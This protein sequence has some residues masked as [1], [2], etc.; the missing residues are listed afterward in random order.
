V[1]IWGTTWAA[2][3]VGLTG[4][5]PLTG[6][7]LR[8]GLAGS[9]LWAVA[10]LLGLRG[11]R[12]AAPPV[13]WVCHGLLTFGVSYGLVYWGEQW[14]PSG[15]AAVLFATF[16]LWVALIAH[17]ALP[18]ERL[19]RRSL[20]G[21]VLG[22]AGVAV[23]FSEDL[24]ALG[25]PQVAFAAAVMLLS[26]LASA[27]AQI[28]VKRWGGQVH[29]VPLNAGAMIIAAATVGVLAALVERHRPVE[30]TGAAVASLLYLALIGTAVAFTLYFWLL[31][32]MAAT[33]LSL[34][35]YA[36]PVVAMGVGA[37]AFDEPITA[38]VLAGTAL[39]IA[40]TALASWRRRSPPAE[41]APAT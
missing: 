25:G 7:A 4:I 26:P 5:P 37:L 41:E 34:T 20:V 35:A 11:G 12:L 38:R 32:H 27:I 31:R 2:I 36:I 9:L 17:F 19:G 40:G 29:P 22:F 21:L 1:A 14:V 18:G 30:F 3:R 10:L 15:L 23:V 13:V 33:T 16:P 28:V 8:F 39:V 24:A 6:V